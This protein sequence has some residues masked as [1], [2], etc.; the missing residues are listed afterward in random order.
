MEGFVSA[1]SDFQAQATWHKVAWFYLYD[2]LTGREVGTL[3]HAREATKSRNVTK[4][5]HDDFYAAEDL[6]DKFINGYLVAG[7][8]RH[9]GMDTIEDQP[10][11]HVFDDSAQSKEDYVIHTIS[12]FVK[13]HVLNPPPCLPGDNVLKCRYCA[14]EYKMQKRLDDHEKKHRELLAKP[15]PPNTVKCHICG[16]LYAKESSLM[17]HVFTHDMDV[18]PENIENTDVDHSADYVYN[19]TRRVLSILTIRMNFE[20]A[21]KRGDGERL[22]LCYKFMYLYFKDASCPKYAYG[23]LETLCQARYLLSEQQANNLMWNRFVNNQGNSDSNLPVDLD[24]EHLNKPL[25]TDLN[26]YRGDITDKSVQ[27]I[28]RS[29]EDSEKVL[30][31]FDKQTGVKK[32]SGKH[33]PVSFAQDVKHVAMLLHDKQV[34]SQ[35]PGRE[36]QHIRK[37]S[38]DALALLNMK[39]I[40]H[41]MKESIGK[42]SNKHYYK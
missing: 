33:E 22:F 9:F 41:W 28:S 17:K 11:S 7:A 21:I 38:A 8:L 26:T 2:T 30:K 13:E 31:N 24:V 36:H 39:D 42:F 19:Y 10:S 29:V 18:Q 35:L 4:D 5:P 6:L 37:I 14:K 15:T 32:P 20:D 16:K 1:L 34:Y 12:S 40:H 27:R 3:Y 25:K 23:V